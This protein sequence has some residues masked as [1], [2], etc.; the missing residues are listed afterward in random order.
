MIETGI[1]TF[2]SNFNGIIEFF[3]KK[4]ISKFSELGSLFRDWNRDFENANP[5]FETG[6]E[7]FKMSIPFSRLGFRLKK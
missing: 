7:T 6:I 5:F 4:I 3:K 2:N 1:E